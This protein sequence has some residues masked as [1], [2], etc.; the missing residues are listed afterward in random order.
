[1][2][3]QILTRYTEGGNFL[4]KYFKKIFIWNLNKMFAFTVANL[5]DTV[6]KPSEFSLAEPFLL[7]E[8]Q[9]FQR[10]KHRVPSGNGPGFKWSDNLQTKRCN[11]IIFET[12][13]FEQPFE[14][15]SVDKGGGTSRC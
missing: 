1:M 11:F 2:S 4:R 10:P 6:T 14:E 9:G 8:K 7:K 15:A 5:S 13:R 12:N 3:F